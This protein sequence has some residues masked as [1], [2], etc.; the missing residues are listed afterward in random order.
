[1][2]TSETNS[3]LNEMV[4]FRVSAQERREITLLARAERLSTSAL[5]RQLLHREIEEAVCPRCSR[6]S[7]QHR[8]GKLSDRYETLTRFVSLLNGAADAA[9]RLSCGR[10]RPPLSGEAGELLRHGEE[11]PEAAE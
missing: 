1:M 5:I 9:V 8:R 10:V 3:P 6:R 4:A 2:T 11:L 7:G